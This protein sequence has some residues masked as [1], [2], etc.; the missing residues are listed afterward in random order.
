MFSC[1]GND[2]TW[3]AAGISSKL[4]QLFPLADSVIVLDATQATN[5]IDPLG[6]PIPDYKAFIKEKNMPGYECIFYFYNSNIMDTAV[7]IPLMKAVTMHDLKTA[8]SAKEPGYLVTMPFFDS[9]GEDRMMSIA[10]P[11][12]S[13]KDSAYLSGL[14]KEILTAFSLKAITVKPKK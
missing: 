6:L 12:V 3:D 4:H 1:T 14:Q 9:R 2:E 5:K 10:L 7:F 11:A 13:E 8:F